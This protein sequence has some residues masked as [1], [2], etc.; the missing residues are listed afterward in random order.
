MALLRKIELDNL[1]YGDTWK[2]FK[3]AESVLKAMHIYDLLI[4]DC[5]EKKQSNF[6][7]II[8]GNKEIP[9]DECS[10]IPGDKFVLCNEEIQ[11]SFLANM[12]INA[13]FQ[14]CRNFFDYV[15]QTLVVF[16][17]E[18]NVKVNSV[19]FAVLKKIKINND[20]VA[21]YVSEIF[22]SKEFKYL[23]DFNNLTK[24]NYNLGIRIKMQVADSTIGGDIPKFKKEYKNKT[25][26]YNSVDIQKA[27]DTMYKFTDKAFVQLC[28]LIHEFCAHHS[29]SAFSQNNN[30]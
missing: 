3:S 20:V 29:N 13:F 30:D 12:Y 15:A 5:F 18:D 11:L 16:F 28:N 4:K 24:H 19:D 25:N 10:L 14:E 27:M 26:N 8:F 2:Y 21:T 7:D 17:S 23:C 1:G 9:E 22:E 6:N